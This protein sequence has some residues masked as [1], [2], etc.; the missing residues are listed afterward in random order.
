MTYSGNYTSFDFNPRSPHGERLTPRTRPSRNAGF[1]ST[2]PA[3][4]ATKRGEGR[5]KACKFQS[6]PP[7]RG[8]TRRIMPG[9]GAIFISIH[10]PRTGSDFSVLAG[11]LVYLL[12]QSTLPA[13]GATW[14]SDAPCQSPTHFNPRSPHGERLRRAS[15]LRRT[16]HFNPRSPHGERLYALDSMSSNSIFQSTLPARG[17]TCSAVHRANAILDFNPRSP[18]GERRRDYRTWYRALLISIHAPRTGSDVPRV[19]SADT[20]RQISIHAPRTGSDQNIASAVTFR[21][22]FQSTLPARGATIQRPCSS[23]VKSRFQSTLP[24]R[25]ATDLCAGDGLLLHI[26]I[27][28]PRTGSDAY[29]GSIPRHLSH[30][31]PRSPHGERRSIEADGKREE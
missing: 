28:A 12:F 5:R 26:S 17:A 3:R 8:A 15:A 11:I 18:H 4:G 25:G 16:P 14:P 10:A 31:N 30:F 23:S 9:G 29:W 1:Q 13:R 24:A 22:A 21:A 20:G 19:Q 2:L 27:H 6:T 7:A